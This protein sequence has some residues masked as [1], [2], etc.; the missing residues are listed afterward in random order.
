MIE[1][2]VEELLQEDIKEKIKKEDYSVDYEKLLIAIKNLLPHFNNTREGIIK[3]LENYSTRKPLIIAYDN[4]KF[5]KAGFCDRIR[6]IL[7][8]KNSK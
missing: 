8:R 7:E 2:L 6:I 3:V 5:Y 1:I 4:E